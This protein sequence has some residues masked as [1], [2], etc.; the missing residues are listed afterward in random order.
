MRTIYAFGNPVAKWLL[1]LV[2]VLYLGAF[3]LARR[4]PRMAV[5]IGAVVAAN[6]LL[7]ALVLSIGQ[8]LFVNQ[9]AGTAFGPASRVFFETL[10]AYLER[11]QEVVLWLGL[12]L[13]VAGLFAGANRYGTAVRRTLS[14]GLEKI[15]IKLGGHRDRRHGP[16]AGWRPTCMA[17]GGRRRARG[18]V[19]L[20]GNNVTTAGCGG[21]W[22]WCWSS[23]PLQ[24]LVGAGREERAGT[25][26][27]DWDNVAG[28]VDERS[29][30]RHPDRGIASPRPVLPG[31]RRSRTFI[32]WADAEQ[33]GEQELAHV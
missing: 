19:L 11:G 4:R 1:P 21:P 24:V 23:S 20:W 8:Q 6:A 16:A 33:R 32:A 30:Q 3:L 26:A 13:V 25:L 29:H 15:G 31:S 28:G 27:P 22:R 17:A 5:W 12:I 10:L 9:L 7:L 14:G 18:V 2:G